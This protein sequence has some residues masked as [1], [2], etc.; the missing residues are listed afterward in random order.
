MFAVNTQQH[1]IHMMQKK[2]QGNKDAAMGYRIPQWLKDELQQL[3]DADDRKL[4]PYV[5]RVL[6]R[7]VTA[8]KERSGKPV[9]KRK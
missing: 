2:P 8:E 6:E 5:Q 4:G 7:H 1:T 9:G 3:A